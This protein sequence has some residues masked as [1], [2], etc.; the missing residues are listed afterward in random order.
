MVCSLRDADAVV[1]WGQKPSHGDASIAFSIA[2]WYA[3]C[4]GIPHFFE[5]QMYHENTEP[6]HSSALCGQP[7]ILSGTCGSRK[8]RDV[9]MDPGLMGDRKSCCVLSK[10]VS[11]KYASTA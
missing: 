3:E 11:R 1:T 10:I 2:V 4:N 9:S 6:N 7:V 5:R 8:R